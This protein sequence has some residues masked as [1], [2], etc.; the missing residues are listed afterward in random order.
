MR[1]AR[2][3]WSLLALAA[4]TLAQ[5]QPGPPPSPASPPPPGPG[6]V[7]PVFLRSLAR[8]DHTTLVGAWGPMDFWAA[9]PLDAVA[10]SPDHRMLF[11]A[12][13]SGEIVGWDLGRYIPTWSI[14]APSDADPGASLSVSAEGHLLLAPARRGAVALDVGGRR[15]RPSPPPPACR[16]AAC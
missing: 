2:P 1:R 16:D 6:P 7:I 15:T 13:R 8:K 14:P 11:A 9:S 4:F 5:P 10:F 12:A 3:L